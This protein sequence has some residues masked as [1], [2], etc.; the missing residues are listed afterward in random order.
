MPEPSKLVNE[1]I[2]TTRL[3]HFLPGATDKFVRGDGSLAPISSIAPTSTPRDGFERILNRST[4]NR[5]LI[6]L[7]FSKPKLQQVNE[8]DAKG[9]EILIPNGLWTGRR[10]VY[11]GTGDHDSRNG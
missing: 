6:L 1:A 2:N 3:G 9:G 5:K 4:G 8:S 7:P 11:D 10:R